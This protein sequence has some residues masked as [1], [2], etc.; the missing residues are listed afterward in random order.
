MSVRLTLLVM[1]LTGAA[2]A[3]ELRPSHAAAS[4]DLALVSC[5]LRGVSRPAECGAFDV[6]EN[7]RTPGRTI[8][9][10]VAVIRATTP[11][12]SA[13]R[14]SIFF[15]TGGPGSAATASAG[16]LSRELA[17][18]SDT[19]DFVF[20]D[21]RGTGGS[22]PL[23]CVADGADTLTPLFDASVAERCRAVLERSADLGAYTTADAVDDLEAVRRALGYQRINLHAS[24]YGTRVA[25]EYA[26]HFPDHARALV[27]HGPAPPGLII[28]LPFAQGLETALEG[29]ITDCLAE[30][31]CAER[32]PR[33]RE[34]VRTAF[35]RLRVSA[36]PVS[37][38][39]ITAHLSQGELSEGVRY[40]LYSPVDARRLPL[41]LAQAAAGDYAPIARALMNHRRGLARDLT[42]GMYLSV[43]C[44]E[45]IPFLTGPAIDAASRNSR[46][47]DYR[48]RQQAAACAVWPRGPAP[49]KRPGTALRVP[50]LLQIG[51]YDPA[52]PLAWGHRAAAMLPE[53]RLLVVPHGGHAFNGLGVDACLWG[54]TASFLRDGSAASIDSSCVAAARRPPFLLQ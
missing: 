53:G 49:E 18:L 4:P 39:G 44:T 1:I 36:V 7:R 26:A 22:N 23:P 27:L 30:P 19:H 41:L 15:F 45:D 40:L 51:E 52:T 50:A 48:V 2:S 11:A 10:R 9:L 35:E 20:V 34:D 47:G 33:L 42:M 13:G 38:D 43:T 6:P 29:V 17:P 24:S 31:S 37:V 3:C 21:Q 5:A 12:P 16:L 32:F 46:L 8:A 25:W 14:D 54:I 28:P